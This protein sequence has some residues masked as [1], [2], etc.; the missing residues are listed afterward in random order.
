[1]L[2]AEYP[3]HTLSKA[4]RAGFFA[5]V[6]PYWE[7]WDY[8]GLMRPPRRKRRRL[9]F[10]KRDVARAVAAHMQ[11]GLGVERVEIDREGRIVVVT[12]QAESISIAPAN[13]WDTVK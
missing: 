6:E 5:A 2:A 13:E 7:P 3:T 11:S 9:A 4:D 8:E 10:T 1:M 12:T